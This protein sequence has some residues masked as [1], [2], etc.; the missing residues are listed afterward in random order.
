MQ[1]DQSCQGRAGGTLTCV[2]LS[3]MCTPCTIC[4]NRTRQQWKRARVVRDGSTK[5]IKWSIKSLI[6]DFLAEPSQESFYT[7][8]K[9]PEAARQ[10]TG[11]N[12]ELL[13]SEVA[14]T[15]PLLR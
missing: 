1:S 8:L 15:E 12:I 5:S 11:L 3:I 14:R 4:Q 13:L 10:R 2:N 9:W 7:V 6:V